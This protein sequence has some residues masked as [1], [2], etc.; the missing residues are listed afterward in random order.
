MSAY[1]PAVVIDIVKT[2]AYLEFEK[3]VKVEVSLMNSQIE[4]LCP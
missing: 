4:C 1:E 2:A 3:E